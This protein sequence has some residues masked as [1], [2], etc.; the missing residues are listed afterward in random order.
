TSFADLAEPAPRRGTASITAYG[1]YLRGRFEYN[2]RTQEG[3][4]EGIR[5]LELAIAEDPGYALAYTGLADSWGLHVD[6][7]SVPVEEGY[8]KA[9][10]YARRALELDDTLAEAHA[11]LAWVLFIH[12]WDWDGAGSAFRRSIALDPRCTV[13]HQW[14]ALLLAAQGRTE[15]SLIEAHTAL[16][17]DPASVSVRRSLG[18]AYYYA[19]RYD[20]ARHH[21]ARAIE[22]NP[23]SE[24]SHRVLGLTLAQDG[25]LA[26]AE[27]VL[28]EANDL[29]DAGPYALGAL[30][31]ALARA[32]KEAEARA[33]LVELE[34]RATRGYVTPVAFSTLYIGLGDVPRALD[35]LEKAFAERRGWLCYLRVNPLLDPLRGEERFKEL[36]ERMRL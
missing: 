27:R 1:L 28:R 20:R 33:L 30:G 7:R 22:M 21:L 26:E 4:A 9:E 29:P 8:R 2:K 3:V 34:S 11:S 10:A 12:D 16:E 15:E 13:A 17:L 23:T 35:W 24:E 19:R 31:Y 25:A 6:Y 18:F 14:Y 36:V 32:G 5:F